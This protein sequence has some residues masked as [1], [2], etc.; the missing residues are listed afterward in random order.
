M[1]K[2]ENLQVEGFTE[3]SKDKTVEIKLQLYN[4]VYFV[5]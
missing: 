4:K 3:T 5:N 2:I 1:D